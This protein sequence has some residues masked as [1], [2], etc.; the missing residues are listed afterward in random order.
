MK[1]FISA[2]LFLISGCTSIQNSTQLK[3]ENAAFTYYS[4]GLNKPTVI[5]ESGLGDD[6]TSWEPVIY[7]VEKIAKVFAYNR[8]GFSGS[9]SATSNRNGNVIVNE[10]RELLKAAKLLPPYIVVGHSLGGTYMELYA[11][12]YPDEVSGVVLVDPYP[13][14]Y[15]E[16]CIIENLD[17]CKP[18]SSIP[19]WASLILPAA[20]EG[21]I[22][23]FGT[24]L[25][26]VNAIN[27]FPDVPL[28]VLSAT[29]FEE[30]NTD[31]Q[32]RHN[33]VDVELKQELS[34]LSSNS[35]HIICDTCGHYIHEDDPDL[36]INAIKWIIK[37]TEVKST[38]KLQSLSEKT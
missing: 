4:S 32:K 9:S 20:I 36:V 19:Y 18:P 11:K 29:T 37:E 16:R 10:L 23:G 12:K 38:K 33:V 22:I 8:A 21:E 3:I 7:D 35:K 24:T 30:P 26:Q 6:M 34:T 27:D 28:V 13:A 17:F 1:I 25:S 31:K 2:L 5:F 15:P 14:K